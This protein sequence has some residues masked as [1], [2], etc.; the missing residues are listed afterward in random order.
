MLT[1]I[2]AGVPNSPQRISAP[3]AYGY[4]VHMRFGLE[5]KELGFIENYEFGVLVVARSVGGQIRWLHEV[6]VKSRKIGA[7]P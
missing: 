6:G 3:T 7:P 2:G 5:V 1:Y 4:E